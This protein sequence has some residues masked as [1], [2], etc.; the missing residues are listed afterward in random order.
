MS[1]HSTIVDRRRLSVSRGRAAAV[2]LG[3]T[4]ALTGTGVAS[5]SGDGSARTGAQHGVRSAERLEL[6]IGKLEREGYQQASCTLSGMRMVNPHTH[7]SV[8]VTY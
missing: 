3:L 4:L 8:T 6:S 2:A 7:R 5:A 1:P